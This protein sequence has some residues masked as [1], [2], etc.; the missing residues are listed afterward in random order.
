MGGDQSPGKQT[1]LEST[2]CSAK[3]TDELEAH[4]QKRGSAA[5][6]KTIGMTNVACMR[7]KDINLEPD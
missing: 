5:D 3:R 2:D 4:V 6:A 7:D 1:T